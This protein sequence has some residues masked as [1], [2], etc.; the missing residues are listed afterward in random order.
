MSLVSQIY[1]GTRGWEMPL[2]FDM[3]SALPDMGEHVAGRCPYTGYIYKSGQTPNNTE[4]RTE[5][6]L[7]A[8]ANRT[9]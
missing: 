1:I 3:N 4:H 8:C 5:P 6:K 7:E 9:A 2:H